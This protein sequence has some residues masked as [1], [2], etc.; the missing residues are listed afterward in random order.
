MAGLSTQGVV[1]EI[2][3]GDPEMP[4]EEVIRGAKARGVRVP[5]DAIR[6]AATKALAKIEM[7]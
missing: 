4:T 2:L 7:K 5:D 6:K 1:R 3:T